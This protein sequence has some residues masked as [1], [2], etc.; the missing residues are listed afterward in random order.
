MDTRFLVATAHQ[1]GVRLSVTVVDGEAV[2][3]EQGARALVHAVTRIQ[4]DTVGNDA[5]TAIRLI[6]SG[7]LSQRDAQ[8]LGQALAG[9]QRSNNR[10]NSIRRGRIPGALSAREAMMVT[11]RFGR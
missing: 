2:L 9:C 6:R 3:D 7:A 11:R 4:S 5:T 8:T 1:M 10:A